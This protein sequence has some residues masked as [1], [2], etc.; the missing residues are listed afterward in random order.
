[1][2]TLSFPN[3]SDN[4]KEESKFDPAPKPSFNPLTPTLK[5]STDSKTTL[6]HNISPSSRQ[7]N[8]RLI[9][10][11]DPYSLPQSNLPVLPSDIINDNLN[12]DTIDV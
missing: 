11:E 6:F 10:E 1:M 8:T 12:S 4:N 2:S 3:S 9:N 5:M 7:P